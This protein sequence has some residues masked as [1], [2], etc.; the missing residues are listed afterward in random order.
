M[1]VWFLKDSKIN[2]HMFRNTANFLLSPL[3][4]GFT[5][6]GTPTTGGAPTSAK[7]YAETF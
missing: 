6:C 2:G 1:G 7:W 4:Q 5:T 3:K